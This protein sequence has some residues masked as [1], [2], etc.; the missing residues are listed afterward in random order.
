MGLSQVRASGPAPQMPPV[1]T[2][3]SSWE[4]VRFQGDSYRFQ[5][6]QLQ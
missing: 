1:V 3:P 6:T 5:D 2:G 4:M